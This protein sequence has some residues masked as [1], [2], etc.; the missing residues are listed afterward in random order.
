M[1]AQEQID[2]GQNSTRPSFQEEVKSI[3]FKINKM[4]NHFQILFMKLLLPWYHNQSI[5]NKK[6]NYTTMP[7][8]TH[9]QSNKEQD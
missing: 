3:F 2:S 8:K 4:R 7:F 5:I 1:Q 6:G 9:I